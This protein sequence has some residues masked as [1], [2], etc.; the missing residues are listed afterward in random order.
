M[1]FLQVPQRSSFSLASRLNSIGALKPKRAA[2]AEAQ[3]PAVPPPAGPTVPAAAGAAAGAAAAGRERPRPSAPQ[4]PV[5]GRPRSPAAVRSA[6]DRAV[7]DDPAGQG[8]AIGGAIGAAGTSSDNDV[9]ITMMRAAPNSAGTGGDG[10][11]PRGSAQHSVPSRAAA[12]ME[13]GAR[14]S[15][16]GNGRGHSHPTCSFWLRGRCR[17]G[18]NCRYSHDTA[19]GPRHGGQQ[20]QQ[21]QQQQ[22]HGPGAPTRAQPHYEQHAAVHT[23]AAAPSDDI[24]DEEI[25]V[26]P[27]PPPRP[28][29]PPPVPPVAAA[30]APAVLSLRLRYSE[31]GKPLNFKVRAEKPLQAVIDAFA[32]VASRYTGGVHCS[33][34]YTFD[35]ERLTGTETPASL[36]MEDGDFIDATEIKAAPPAAPP[37]AAP[38]A[39]PAA[40]PRPTPQD[41]PL[42][43]AEP[44]RLILEHWQR[45]TLYKVAAMEVHFRGSGAASSMPVPSKLTIDVREVVDHGPWTQGLGSLPCA[46]LTPAAD[47][48]PTSPRDADA[49]RHV[50]AFGLAPGGPRVAVIRSKRLCEVHPSLAKLFCPRSAVDDLPS[51][52]YLVPDADSSTKKYELCES[53]SVLLQFCR[54]M[55]L[56]LR[57]QNTLA[58]SQITTPPAPRS[59]RLDD[60]EGSPQQLWGC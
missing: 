18:T 6:D 26:A 25:F 1:W 41:A 58:R 16:G 46:T 54:A 53:T 57:S 38:L 17:H 20:Q 36:E 19:Q 37:A 23:A 55:S 27:P 56:P 10:G 40:A 49:F 14:D 5:A 39:A 24:G 33:Y 9:M 8:A 29:A 7:R 51:C 28:T 3:P 22:Q 50:R 2:E 11:V 43:R 21:Q 34:R 4:Q 45:G 60:L 44:E 47:Q 59:P 13:A 48:T 15:R 52:F 12:P 35:G 42:R 30:A 32:K 31:T